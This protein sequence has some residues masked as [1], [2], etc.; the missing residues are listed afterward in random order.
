MG[1][2]A[3]VVTLVT[4]SWLLTLVVGKTADAK[5]P[6]QSR[7]QIWGHGSTRIYADQEPRETHPWKSVLIRG[8]SL[9][10]L[11]GIELGWPSRQPLD[12][13]CGRGMRGK[14]TGEAHA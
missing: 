7:N 10:S 2:L 11:H 1:G 8:R 6:G 14:K 13:F 9:F 4:R 3:A 12:S 5:C